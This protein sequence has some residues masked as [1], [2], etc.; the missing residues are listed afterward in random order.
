MYNMLHSCIKIGNL[1]ASVE[2]NWQLWNRDTEIEKTI[3][4]IF[5]YILKFLIH[6]NLLKFNKWQIHT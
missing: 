6:M 1:V 4:C 5:L 3:P 2:E